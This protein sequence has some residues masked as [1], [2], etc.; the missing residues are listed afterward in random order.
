MN[1]PQDFTER[2]R[3]ILKDEYTD[4]IKCY[5]SEG[6]RA[7]RVNTLK[8]SIDYFLN[9]QPW[10]L[11]QA[12]NVPWCKEG[13]YFDEPEIGTHPFHAAGAYYIQEPSAMIPVEKLDVRPGL[14]VLD[15][16]ASPGGKSTQIAAKLE[17]TGLLICN[18][19]NSQRAA[20]LSENIER[21]GVANALVISHE[22]SLISERFPEFFDRVLVDSPC[23]GEGMFRKN[24]EAV[25][26]WSVSNVKMCAERSGDILYHASLTLKPGGLL[27]YSTCTFAP[28]EDEECIEAFLKDDPGF[29]LLHMDKAWPDKIK[30]EGHFYAILK[31]HEGQDFAKKIKTVKG[32]SPKSISDYFDFQKENLKID[33][34]KLFKDAET[35]YTLFG[36]ELYALREDTPD[37][38]GL[39]VLRPGLHLGTLKKNRFEPSFAF[40]HFLKKEDVYNFTDI[41]IDTARS[42]IKGN[43]FPTDGSKGYHLI[44]TGGYS[45]SWGKQSDGIMKN[46]YPKGLRR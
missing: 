22:P 23:S 17:N 46:H 37:L 38:K 36:S 21:M 11:S 30:G 8:G 4:F 33:T 31:K 16:C 39:K 15:M 24:P 29:E 43:T 9:T 28:E 32:V 3:T 20:V 44:T 41:D 40:S 25:E 13:F 34:K 42:Y 45:L 26:M 2:I 27:V 35:V 18:E 10:G 14:K 7:L 6:N 5:E 1:L 12:D 19:I